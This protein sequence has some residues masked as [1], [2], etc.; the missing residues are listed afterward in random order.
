MIPPPPPTSQFRNNFKV[1]K[2]EIFYCSDFHDFSTIKFLQEG[3]CGVKKNCK[4]Y[5]GVHLGPQNSLHIC[6]V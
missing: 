1:P 6:S 5:L 3:D 2:F 4:K